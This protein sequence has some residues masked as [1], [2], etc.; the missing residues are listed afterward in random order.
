MI[1]LD[2][3][4]FLYS[5]NPKSLYHKNSVTLLKRLVQSEVK[6]QTST[7]SIQEVV[8]V[9]KR[10]D[11]L[12]IGLNLAKEMLISFK[13]LLTVDSETIKKYLGYLKKYPE[14]ESRDCLHLAVCKQNG[15]KTMI[16]EDKHLRKIKS[17]R[18]YSIEEYLEIL[19]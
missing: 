4:V 18:V 9:L 16:T 15:V 13:E 14:L 2:A 12:E 19:G 1:Y 7:E 6:A 8:H 11:Q 10:L 5:V 17:L 3:N